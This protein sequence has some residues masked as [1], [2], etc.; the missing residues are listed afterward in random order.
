MSIVTHIAGERTTNSILSL[1]SWF[2][3]SLRSET[4]CLS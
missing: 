4:E 1:D 3:K 2:I